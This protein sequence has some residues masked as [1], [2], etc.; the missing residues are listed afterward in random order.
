VNLQ[1]FSYSIFFSSAEDEL[2]LVMEYIDGGDVMQFLSA[3]PMDE[4]LYWRLFR[5]MLCAV[6]YM[7][8]RDVIHCDIKPA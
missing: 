7:H 2:I 1:C 4:T 5:Q 3:G 6:H 8:S